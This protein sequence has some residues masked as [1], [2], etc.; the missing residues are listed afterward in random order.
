MST[1][2]REQLVQKIV[3]ARVKDVL[4]PSDIFGKRVFFKTTKGDIVRK[5]RAEF[6][7]EQETGM[8]VKIRNRLNSI[9]VD[10][11][12]LATEALANTANQQKVVVQHDEGQRRPGRP[13]GSKNK[14]KV[15][16]KEAAPETNQNAPAGA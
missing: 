7:E 2:K 6:S 12:G 15:M 16:A 11:V 1:L 13:K 9:I 14:A 5:I 3:S 10:S 4:V 8:V